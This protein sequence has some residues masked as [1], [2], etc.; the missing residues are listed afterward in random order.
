[1]PG[2]LISGSLEGMLHSLPATVIFLYAS[3]RLS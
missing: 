2:R 3:L 1:M